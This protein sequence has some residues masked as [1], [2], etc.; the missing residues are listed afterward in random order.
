M[1]GRRIA[2]PLNRL[3]VR[4]RVLLQYMHEAD[5]HR[6]LACMVRVSDVVEYL[7]WLPVYPPPADDRVAVVCFATAFPALIAPDQTKRFVVLAAAHGSIAQAVFYH[8]RK[9][10]QCSPPNPAPNCLMQGGFAPD[11]ESPCEHAPSSRPR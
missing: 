1:T 7:R 11:P 10:S 4:R 2:V 9:A 3:A 5:I 8:M 6:R